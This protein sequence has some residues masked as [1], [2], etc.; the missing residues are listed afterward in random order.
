MKIRIP[1]KE[2]PS[3][4]HTTEFNAYSD[5]LETAY[6][7]SKTREP[8]QQEPDP[9]NVDEEQLV[10]VIFSDGT[11]WY[12]HAGELPQLLGYEPLRSADGVFD[13]P[14]EIPLTNGR[15]GIGKKIGLALL[16]FFKPKL[17]EHVAEQGAEMIAEALE[18]KAIGKSGEGLY[19]VSSELKLFSLEGQ[20]HVLDLSRPVLLLIHGTAS[21]TAG[22]FK[23]LPGNQ[24]EWENIRKIYKSNIIALEHRSLTKSPVENLQLLLEQLPDKITLHLLTMSRGGQVGELLCLSTTSST[25][26][27]SA[28]KYL[29][30]H[31]RQKDAECLIGKNGQADNSLSIKQLVSKKQVKVEK[32]VRVACPAQGTN[33]LNNRIDKVLNTLF[34]LSKLFTNPVGDIIIGEL[35]ALTIAIAQQRYDPDVLPGLETMVM[36]SPIPSL[37]NSV[38][39]SSDPGH[40]LYV[41]SGNSHMDSLLNILVW[42]VARPVFRTDNDFIVDTDSMVLGFRRAS[43]AYYRHIEGNKIYHLG[44][45]GNANAVSSIRSALEHKAGSVPPNF[46]EIRYGQEN[47]GLFGLPDGSLKLVKPSGQK[48]IVLLLPG[49]MGSN[50]SENGEEV[51]IDYGL[52]LLGGLKR[53][54]YNAAANNVKASSIIRDAYGEFHDFLMKKGFDVVV[55]P[56]DWRLGLEQS[57]KLLADKIK[58]CLNSAPGKPVHIVAH[59]MGGLVARDVMVNH[60]ATWELLKERDSDFRCILL[61]TPWQGSYL[62]PQVL[63]GRGNTIN[64]LARLDLAHS[65]K[66]L[67]SYFSLYPGIYDLMPIDE[68]AHEFD[69]KAL[70]EKVMKPT[71]DDNWVLPE[72]AALTKARKYLEKARKAEPDWS[73]IY[74][75][76]GRS[77]TTVSNFVLKSRYGHVIKSK[78]TADILEEMKRSKQYSLVFTA[79]PRGDGSVTWDMGIPP[80]IRERKL[81]LYYMDTVHGELAND[82]RYFEGIH[83]LLQN[84]ITSRLMR[85]EPSVRSAEE[86][87]L[88]PVPYLPNDPDGLVRSMLNM[89]TG[90]FIERSGNEDLPP[91]NVSVI[92]GHLKFAAYP[93]LVGH[94]DREGIVNAERVLD[95]QMRFALTQRERMGIY[96][97]AIGSNLVLLPTETCMHGA[98]VVGLGSQETLTPHTLSLTVEKGC[99][100]YMLDEACNCAQ[101]AVKQIGLSSLLVGSSYA[102]MSLSSCMTAILNGIINANRHILEFGASG[103]QITDVEFVE[104]YRDRAEVAYYMLHQIAKDGNGLNLSIAN[105]IELKEGARTMMDLDESRSWWTRISALTKDDLDCKKG[106]YMSAS[107]NKARVEERKVNINPRIIEALLRENAKSTQWDTVLAK[108][109][110]EMIIPNDFKIVFRNQHNIQWIL[111]KTT[112]HLPVELLHY[113]ANANLPI[114][115][116][117]GMIRQMATPDSRQVAN[118]VTAKSALVIGDPLLPLNQRTS[119]LPEAEREAIVVD[120][121]LRQNKY[122]TRMLLK[123]SATDVFKS[124][125]YDYRVIHIAAHGVIDYGEDHETGILLSDGTEEFVLTTA[126]IDQI[127]STPE[128]VFIN[129]CYMGE[130]DPEKERHFRDRFRLAANIGPQFIENGVRA[131]VVAG[132]AVNDSAAKRFAEV[133]YEKMLNGAEFGEAVKTARRVCFEEFPNTNTWGAYQC[134]GDPF[135]QLNQ[136][137]PVFGNGNG[138]FILPK[139][140]MIALETW[141]NKAKSDGYPTEVLVKD[142]TA[143][144]EKIRLSDFGNNYGVLELEAQCYAEIA[145]IEKA[146]ELFQ[147]LFSISNAQYSSKTLELYYDLRGMQLEPMKQANGGKSDRSGQAPDFT[148]LINKIEAQKV[149]QGDTYERNCLLGLTYR[150]KAAAPG[151][152]LSDISFMSI[153]FQNAFELNNGSSVSAKYHALANWITAACLTVTDVDALVKSTKDA[154]AILKKELQ[155]LA[156]SKR[157]KDFDQLYKSVMLNECELLF[158]TEKSKHVSTVNRIKSDYE[159]ALK[160]SGSRRTK[161]EKVEQ[162]RF[163]RK[164]AGAYVGANKELYQAAIEELFVFYRKKL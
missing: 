49:I 83:E 155:T 150:R 95:I 158:I 63:T 27:D 157:H 144:S 38:Q 94:F 96:P 29:A 22:S 1:G 41:L 2:K 25:F 151:G 57:G 88:L 46:K 43:R 138:P 82:E 119:Q 72:Q 147:K 32:F 102:N 89:K 58:E 161:M 93:L 5:F 68:E 69:Q 141:L 136:T 23:K 149:F 35:Q 53:L 105:G 10:E 33:L 21:H 8:G 73:N 112:A 132:W 115:A 122:E 59:S 164:Y 71:T 26:P 137:T 56:F 107:T 87:E 7:I 120:E 3:A 54:Q 128:F 126:A 111:D 47:R 17:M 133:F 162:M 156:D 148:N 81:N 45:F 34:N 74:Y 108:T 40:D 118:H 42:P 123:P 67:L 106:I 16:R 55:F 146:I 13:L 6:E 20:Q 163:L 125:Y 75:I 50:L 130:V 64:S 98:V 76:A 31:G 109:L 143:I 15:G 4:S 36:G 19:L 100:A 51:W 52:M 110:F 11:T 60:K 12:A 61:G 30:A 99:L 85:S 101:D 28:A 77:D 14:T 97:G 44:Y 80:A 9:I 24:K 129:C 124:L 134:Y 86:V 113:D 91:L 92:N 78:K 121:L 142:L 65:K 103:P 48:P 160:L 153:H 154:R 117:A 39:Q 131:V 127:S 135:Y 140:A 62:I 18:K 116:T 114:G 104:L 84:G 70:W 66:D 139:E 37:I 90:A 79:T 145:L 152:S 159:K